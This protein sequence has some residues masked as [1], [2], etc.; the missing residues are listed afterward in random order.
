MPHSIRNLKVAL[1]RTQAPE[2]TS[3]AIAAR[4]FRLPLRRTLL[5][6]HLGKRESRRDC[7]DVEH[8]MHWI[9][10]QARPVQAFTNFSFSIVDSW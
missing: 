9:A 3:R 4:A 6:L 2:T 10:W 8:G 1:G 5:R 7:D